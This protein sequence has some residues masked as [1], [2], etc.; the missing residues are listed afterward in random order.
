MRR[1]KKNPAVPTFGI[2]W[3][4]SFWKESVQIPGH[5]SARSFVFWRCRE[6]P[7]PA[8]LRLTLITS[9]NLKVTLVGP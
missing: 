5:D 8:A 1:Y 6:K 9:F 2:T 4:A 7:A 3:S